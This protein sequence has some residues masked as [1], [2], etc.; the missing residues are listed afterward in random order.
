MIYYEN[1][2]NNLVLLNILTTNMFDPVQSDPVM[3]PTFADIDLDGD[4]DFFTG[5]TVG[6]VTFYENIGFAD[7]LPLFEFVTNFWEEIY[8]VGSSQQRHGAS[9]IQFIP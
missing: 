3:T 5:N 4:L 1:N 8:I 2:Q 7:N 6:T 9:A